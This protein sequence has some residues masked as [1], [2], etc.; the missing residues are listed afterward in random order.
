[1]LSEEHEMIWY[2]EHLVRALQGSRLA[3]RPPRVARAWRAVPVLAAVGVALRPAP[4][5]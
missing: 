4:V 5:R 3:E 2:N 1:M